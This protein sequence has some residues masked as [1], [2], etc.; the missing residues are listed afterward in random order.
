MTAPDH[1]DTVNQLIGWVRDGKPFFQTRFNDGEM[2]AMFQTRH[3]AYR[4]AD[5]SLYFPEIGEALFRMLQELASVK[6]ISCIQ[7]GSSWMQVPD[8]EA[9]MF[10]LCLIQLGLLDRLQW[11]NGHDLLDGVVS[12]V[13]LDLLKALRESRRPIILV[14]KKSIVGVT[15][16]LRATLVEIP[17]SDWWLSRDRIVPV[18]D[19]FAKAGFT[20]VWCAGIAKSIM[21]DVWR[22]HP[23]SSHLDFGHIFDGIDGSRTREW[24]RR[25]ESPWWGPYQ[26]SFLP[27]IRSF[28]P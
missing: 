19:E 6:D 24:M 5:D 10:K 28:N 15:R 22:K 2:L 20:F 11:A 17:P 25:E 13:T 27:Y 3:A 26:D 1:R 7:I 23:Q 18:C 14:G 16:C 8:A 4:S 21:W 12:G 9:E